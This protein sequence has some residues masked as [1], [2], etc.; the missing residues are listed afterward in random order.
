M[1]RFRSIRRCAAWLALV[2]PGIIGGVAFSAPATAARPVASAA[3]QEGVEKAEKS[4]L[5]GIALDDGALRLTGGEEL[6]AIRKQLDAALEGSGARR[7]ADEVLAWTAPGYTGPASA[8]KLTDA[9]A[10]AMKA[11]GYAYETREAENGGAVVVARK[12]EGDALMGLWIKAPQVLVLAWC[13]VV[14]AGG[15][16]SAAAAAEPASAKPAGA[17]DASAVLAAGDPALTRQM[18]EHTCHFLAYLL[19]APLTLEQKAAL[20]KS[21]VADW[22]KKDADTIEFVKD[23]CDLRAQI[24]A[25]PEAERDLIRKQLQPEILKALRANKGDEG[26]KWMLAIYDAAHRPLAPGSPPLT[27]QMTD[28]YAE[29]LYFMA[30][31]VVGEKIAPDA[32]AKATMAKG[33]ASAYAKAPAEMKKTLNQMPILWAAI[34][35]AWPTLPEAEKAAAREQW[36]K[37]FQVLAPKLPAASPKTASAA[38][39]P[40]K[41]SGAKSGTSSSSSS[42]G[43]LSRRMAAMQAMQSAYRTQSQM[44]WQNHY[45]RM[46]SINTMG[47]NPYRYV[48]AYGNP[49]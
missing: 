4:R 34:R 6:A 14:S 7:G 43:D 17:K 15:E 16:K 33:L 40:S 8:A 12:G 10:A 3:R 42:A 18:V 28:A 27:R 23:A 48:N 47:G 38:A 32:E 13:R 11:A 29:V 39:K 31:E 9:V 44:M 5:T 21:I 26:A 45:S 25:K 35:V 22:K 30:S 24:F 41:S 1:A 37:D 2:S 46:N 36:K 19:E 49:Y 20:E